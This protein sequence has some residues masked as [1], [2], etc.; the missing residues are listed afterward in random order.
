MIRISLLKTFEAHGIPM[1]NVYV[2][3]AGNMA[4]SSAAKQKGYLSKVF[5]NWR[6]CESKIV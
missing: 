4:G 6:I 1:K 5:K 3:R 2:E